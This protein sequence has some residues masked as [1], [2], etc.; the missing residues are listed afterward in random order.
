MSN[1]MVAA[2]TE[3]MVIEGCVR[4][5]TGNYHFEFN[6]IEDLF[7]AS[8]DDEFK[9]SISEH[10]TENYSYMVAELDME[11]DFDFMFY[12]GYCP[13]AAGEA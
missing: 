7:G 13:N 10:I 5:I 11:E 1:G 4:T 6:E 12:T 3:Y 2:V 9:E 8:I